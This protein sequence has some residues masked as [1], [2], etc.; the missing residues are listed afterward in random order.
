MRSSPES[1]APLHLGLVWLLRHASSEMAGTGRW[2]GW[3]DVGL[4][5]EGRKQAFEYR[6]SG[7]VPKVDSIYSSP[8]RR[9]IETASIL[10]PAEEVILDSR[11]RTRHLGAWEGLTKE[12][13]RQ[14]GGVWFSP[15][16]PQRPPGG[17][18]LAEVE[19]RV[20]QS[21]T[22]IFQ[23]GHSAVLIVTH[24]AV[25]GLTLQAVGLAPTI[26]PPCTA[27]ALEHATPHRWSL[28][29]PPVGEVPPV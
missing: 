11:L 12:E 27:I 24:G 28:R 26:V 5:A 25:I 7:M 9:C 15:F 8:L 19:S 21:L 13:I 3:R 29:V 16:A 20:M 10:A 14:E 1:N 4:S 22:D 18:S 17:E 23:T 2:Q 6:Q